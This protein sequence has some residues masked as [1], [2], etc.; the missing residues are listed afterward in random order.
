MPET[1][2]DN[3]PVQELKTI[4][5]AI[6]YGE[7]VSHWTRSEQP[8]FDSKVL[9][10]SVFSHSVF[11][12][13]PEL[14]ETEIDTDDSLLPVQVYRSDDSQ[15]HRVQNNNVQNNSCKYPYL[16]VTEDMASLSELA[17]KLAD[18]SAT[19]ND[20]KMFVCDRQIFHPIYVSFFFW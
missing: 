13:S 18:F 12:F 5:D 11:R 8:L 20:L 4:Y 10:N 9:S 19:E 3:V 1:N 6:Q 17:L 16:E 7:N 2:N 15:I 14:S